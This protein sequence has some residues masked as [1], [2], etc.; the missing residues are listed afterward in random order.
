MHIQFAEDVQMVLPELHVVDGT[1]KDPLFII[2][3]DM[4]APEHSGLWDFLHVGF[5]LADRRGAMAFVDSRG[6]ECTVDLASW[7][8]CASRWVQLPEN[9]VKALR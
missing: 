8:Q 3:A 9:K 4:M 7:P 6:N 5:H 2:G 1:R